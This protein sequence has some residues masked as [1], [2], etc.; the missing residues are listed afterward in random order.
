MRLRG[1][2]LLGLIALLPMLALAACGNDTPD[3][4]GAVTGEAVT[5]RLAHFPNLTHAPAIYGLEK[6]IFK[7]A[8]GDNVTINVKTFNAGT[9]V[10]T[11]VFSDD[12]DISYI[13]PNP[14]I[15]GFQ[16]SDG[17]AVQIIAG[18]TS[19]GAALVVR[20]EI[21]SPDQLK[22]TTL[23]TPSLGNTQDVALRAWLAERGLNA[24]KEGGGDVSVKPQENAQ[25]LQAFIDRQID[26]AW[27]PE[28]WASRL[29]LEGGGKV[30][31]DEGTLW[32][33]GKYATTLVIVRRKFSDEHPE[34][35]ENFLKGHVRVI[36]EIA[37]D[38][39][40]AQRVVNAG[41]A[42]ISGKPLAAKV[43][44]AAWKNLEFTYDPLI[45]TIEQSATAA[46]NVGLLEDSN[47][48]GIENLTLLNRVLDAEGKE[49]VDT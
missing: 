30:L 32:P 29:V 11:G 2:N 9:D 1:I 13:G 46:K 3:T 12:I 33:D 35:V 16:Q 40:E 41:I 10:V 31:L 6:G 36:E 45:A 42:K 47:I 24:T 8:L 17:K 48:E 34:V 25:T 37:K 15:N 18:A 4:S 26:G 14:A 19:G 44:A 7:E 28:P 39:A 23:S 27:V 5:L 43:L 49:P 22:G 21:T 20:P 38:E